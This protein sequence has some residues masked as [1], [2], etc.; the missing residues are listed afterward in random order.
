MAIPE[1]EIERIKSNV[2]L[3]D[4]IRRR[5]VELKRKGKQLWGLCPF[6]AED[7]PSLAVDERKGLWN[8]LGKCQTGGDVFSFVMESDGINFKEAFA[9]LSENAPSKSANRNEK[10]LEKEIAGA[11]EM[12]KTELEYLEKATVY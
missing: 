3:A 2:S 8:C 4:V 7:E 10:P 6:H 12:T 5:G 1:S 11:D 9:L